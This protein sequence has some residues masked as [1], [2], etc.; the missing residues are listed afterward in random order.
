[1]SE[2]MRIKSYYFIFTPNIILLLFG[3]KY[4]FF[5]KIELS[6]Q[7]SRILY[8]ISVEYYMKYQNIGVLLIL[9]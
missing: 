9:Y 7:E 3:T 4:K 8:E 1:M 5:Q 2:I 6:L